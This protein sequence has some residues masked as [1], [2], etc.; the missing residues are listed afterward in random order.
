M[1]R[2]GWQES[3]KGG[4]QRPEVSQLGLTDEELQA[5]RIIGQAGGDTHVKAVAQELGIDRREVTILCEPLAEGDYI[6]LFR[7]GRCIMKRRGRE[8]LEQ[9]R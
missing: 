2:A 3:E 1:K 6:D 5:L 7:S 4:Y 8:A 9:A